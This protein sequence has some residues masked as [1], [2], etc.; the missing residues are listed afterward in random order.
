MTLFSST[1]T[2]IVLSYLCMGNTS[3]FDHAVCWIGFN[4]CFPPILMHTAHNYSAL[5]SKVN[6]VYCIEVMKASIESS[7]EEGCRGG[8][9]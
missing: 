2:I 4:K 5:D 1:V 6:A 7:A 9:Y 3:L 8:L